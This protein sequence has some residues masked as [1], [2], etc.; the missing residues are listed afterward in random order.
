ML[1]VIYISLPP[2]TRSCLIPEIP[3]TPVSVLFGI[4]PSLCFDLV[5]CPLEPRLSMGCGTRC[6]RTLWISARNVLWSP[7]GIR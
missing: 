4:L 5:E 1:H 3:E 7:L 6:I 2:P